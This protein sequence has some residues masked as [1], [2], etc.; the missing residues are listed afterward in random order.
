[1]PLKLKPS[2]G[3]CAPAYKAVRTSGNNFALTQKKLHRLKLLETCIND[4]LASTSFKSDAR[5]DG[6][7]ISP[8]LFVEEL[9]ETAVTALLDEYVP[10]SFDNRGMS[11]ELGAI[12]RHASELAP[13]QLRVKEII[14]TVEVFLQIVTFIGAQPRTRKQN[15]SPIVDVACGHGLLAVLLAYRYPH[16]K[17]IACDTKQREV[18]DALRAG[19]VKFGTT[20]SKVKG[21]IVTLE[22]LEF[23][24]GMF[25]DC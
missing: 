17:V 21:T 23:A 11:Q 10:T 24:E 16:R 2:R 20:E 25:Q 8:H 19:F 4:A 5:L 6:R 18:Y 13:N 3:P 7:I 14:E 1:M 22:N 12:F 9:S 15:T